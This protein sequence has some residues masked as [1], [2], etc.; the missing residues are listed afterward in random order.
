M[1]AEKIIAF[2]RDPEAPILSAEDHQLL[3]QLAAPLT[4]SLKVAKLYKESPCYLL[5]NQIVLDYEGKISL[6]C[7]TV[8]PENTGMARFLEM[9]LRDLQALRRAHPTCTSCTAT[10]T[11]IYAGQQGRP[12]FH[13]LNAATI[14]S[15]NTA[16]FNDIC[17]A[18][19]T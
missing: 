1:P 19:Q 17:G 4:E 12:E 3:E 7:A 18:P 10:A 11:H 14:V 2:A 5:G 15:E 13:K 16:T 6:C 8:A 9:H